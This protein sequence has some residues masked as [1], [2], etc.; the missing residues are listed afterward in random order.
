MFGFVDDDWKFMDQFGAF[1]KKYARFDM[2]I[3]EMLELHAHLVK[4]NK[5]RNKVKDAIVEDVKIHP[6]PA[7]VEEPKA[8]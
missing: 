3:D 2:G 8:P 1:L 5:L 4:Y 7:P 6:A